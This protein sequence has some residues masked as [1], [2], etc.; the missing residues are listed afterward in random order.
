MKKLFE[1]LFTDKENK[2][3]NLENS[4]PGR[5][6]YPDIPKYIF[7]SYED[8]LDTVKAVFNAALSS[9]SIRMG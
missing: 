8:N 4:L 3:F 1:K 7:P 2:S 9:D 6:V 5:V